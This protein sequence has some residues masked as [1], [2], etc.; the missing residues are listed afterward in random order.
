MEVQKERR[1]NRCIGRRM[2]GWMNGQMG[3]WM[4]GRKG[5]TGEGRKRS[6]SRY[7]WED[8]G[9]IG[10]KVGKVVITSVNGQIWPNC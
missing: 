6:E 5:G 1:K 3:G 7:N 4:E 10:E 9:R 8:R 2:V